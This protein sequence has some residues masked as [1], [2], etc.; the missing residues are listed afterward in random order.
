MFQPHSK[1]TDIDDILSD[2]KHRTFEYPKEKWIYYQEWN[3]ALF[4]HWTVP[5][6]I[7][8]D[9][10]PKQLNIDTFQGDAYVSMVAFT[11][12]KIRPRYLP[13][14]NFISN[15]DEINIRTYIDNDNKKG[16]FFLNIE[17][18][19]MLS[20]FIAKKLSGLPYEKANIR[21]NKNNYQSNNQLKDFH[22]NVQYEIKE[23]LNCKTE[24]EN[25][26]T[27]RYCLY[28]ENRSSIYCY[29]IHHK[30]W[31]IKNVELKHLDLKYTIGKLNLTNNPDI[32]QYS[33]GVQVVAWNKQKL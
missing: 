30:E 16:V 3:R 5:F 26:L 10:V 31:Q 8:R 13:A 32:I 25:W 12:E 11:M 15:F 9:L 17:A 27:E 7:L 14:V 24:L 6:D 4:L 1:M 29:D 19:K 21:R 23:V 33:D 28:V 22:L 2:T 18:Q 20:V